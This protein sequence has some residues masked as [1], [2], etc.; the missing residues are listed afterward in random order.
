[1][2]DYVLEIYSTRQLDPDHRDINYYGDD[3]NAFTQYALVNPHLVSVD[4]EK[5]ISYSLFK[6]ETDFRVWVMHDFSVLLNSF[7]SAHVA[8][9]HC[10]GGTKNYCTRCDMEYFLFL[11]I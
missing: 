5:R 3:Q 2:Y 1:M 8:S 7:K 10:N 6:E 9:I 4:T 11:S